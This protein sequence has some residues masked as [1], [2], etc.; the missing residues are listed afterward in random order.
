MVQTLAWRHWRYE[1]DNVAQ[2]GLVCVGPSGSGLTCIQTSW[3][4]KGGKIMKRALR[5]PMLRALFV[6]VV[7]AM[8]HPVTSYAAAA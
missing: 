2:D 8:A 4:G 7:L 1:V 6:L 5:G 3:F